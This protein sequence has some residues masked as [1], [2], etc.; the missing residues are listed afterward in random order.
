MEPRIQFARPA[1]NFLRS[2]IM[3]TATIIS[4]SLEETL[5][6]GEKIGRQVKEATV[7]ALSGDLG[8]GKTV[9]VQGLAKGLNVPSDY[10]VTSPTYT[11]INEYPGRI[12]LFHIDLYRISGFNELEEIGIYDIVYGNHITAIEWPDRFDGELP[13]N[14]LKIRIEIIDENSRKFSFYASGTQKNPLI[15]LLKES[16]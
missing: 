7:I 11:L 14:H 5:N 1:R 12:K 3:N 4:H 6:L 13:G 10:Y 9:F 8:S 15:T 2:Y 16:K